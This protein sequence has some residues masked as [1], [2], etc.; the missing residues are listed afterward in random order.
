MM[1]DEICIEFCEGCNR[2]RCNE[3]HNRNHCGSLLC[4]DVDSLAAE[5]IAALETDAYDEAVDRAISEKYTIPC[6]GPM[7]DLAV[8]NT[9]IDPWKCVK[10]GAVHNGT[11]FVCGECTSNKYAETIRQLWT[12]IGVYCRRRGLSSLQFSGDRWVA[13]SEIKSRC[14]ST[15]FTRP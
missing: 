12:A 9:E 1:D 7:R 14:D 5:V 10:C 4:E 15:E 11:R 8:Y 6:P 2:T 13:A 3:I